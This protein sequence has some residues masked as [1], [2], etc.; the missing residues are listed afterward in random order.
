MRARRRFER[1]ER[2][3]NG[4]TLEVW[5]E[6]DAGVFTAGATVVDG[7]DPAGDAS[8]SHSQLFR[9]EGGD[10]VGELVLQTPRAYIL[11]VPVG[12]QQ[13][14]KA[15]VSTR[16]RRPAASG[17]AAPP[18][19]PADFF[20]EFDEQAEGVALCGLIVKTLQGGN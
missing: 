19:Q 7:S 18:D 6:G 16:I 14:G 13:A 10:D 4:S 15:K 9:S 11:T 5:V 1:R 2:V 8:F 20:W 17:V 3:P 12:F